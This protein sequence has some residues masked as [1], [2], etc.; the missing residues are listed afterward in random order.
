MQ[1]AKN[2]TSLEKLGHLF[3]QKVAGEIA[4]DV[5]LKEAEGLLK[6]AAMVQRSFGQNIL[7]GLGY[8]PRVLGKSMLDHSANRNTIAHAAA[9]K[10]G[11]G[12]GAYGGAMLGGAEQGLGKWLYGLG[13]AGNRRALK[14]SGVGE[15]IAKSNFVTSDEFDKALL[16]NAGK[17]SQPVAAADAAT[18][19][20]G[21]P[22]NIILQQ[23]Q[24]QQAA[25]NTMPLGHAALGAA[26]LLGGGALASKHFSQPQMPMPMPMQR[27]MMGMM[28]MP[29][30]MPMPM[31]MPMPM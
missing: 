25:A 14:S 30:L 7:H 27:P 17:A 18:T 31:T 11:G 28:P 15:D 23:P 22:L 20:A 9:A 10:A 4:E 3:M 19:A 24:V 6:E 16:R 13:T 1:E 29:M 26:T 21:Q 8:L 12:S 5:F 2:N